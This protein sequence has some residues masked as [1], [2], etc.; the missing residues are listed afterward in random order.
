VGEAT[1]AAVVE[2]VA[3]VADPPVRPVIA[4]ATPVNAA[5]AALSVFRVER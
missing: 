2:L 4:K 3:A 1:A 5:A